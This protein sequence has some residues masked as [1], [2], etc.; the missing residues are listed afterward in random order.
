MTQHNYYKTLAA[1]NIGIANIGAD[2]K[3]FSLCNSI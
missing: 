3:T 2:G 1:Y